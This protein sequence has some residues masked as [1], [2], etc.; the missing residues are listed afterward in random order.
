MATYNALDELLPGPAQAV[1]EPAPT[2]AGRV[3]GSRRTGAFNVLD[4]LLPGPAQAR[5]EPPAPVR[6][7]ARPR[8][9]GAYNPL[10]ILLPGEPA[11]PAP[12]RRRAAAAKPARVRTTFSVSK[13]LLL[14]MRDVLGRQGGSSGR[15]TLDDLA[16]R[17]LTAELERLTGRRTRSRRTRKQVT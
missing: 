14:A 11:G 16:E 10:D 5:P 3:L 1:P 9:M 15:L 2:P 17:A 6:Q 8:A 12:R 13:E 7:E 4:E